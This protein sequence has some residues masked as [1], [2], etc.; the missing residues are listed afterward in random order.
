MASFGEV[1]GRL[2]GGGDNQMT[3]ESWAHGKI[4]MHIVLPYHNIHRKQEDSLWRTMLCPYGD[5][6]KSICYIEARQGSEGG[7]DAERKG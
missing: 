7:D 1:D 2:M 6:K 5:H 3:K 4:S